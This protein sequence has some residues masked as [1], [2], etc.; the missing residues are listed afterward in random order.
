[1]FEDIWKMRVQANF[2]HSKT[3]NKFLY[4]FQNAHT[5]LLAGLFSHGW[6]VRQS[7]TQYILLIFRKRF[8]SNVIYCCTPTS[9]HQKILYCW[10]SCLNVLRNIVKAFK[11]RYNGLHSVDDICMCVYWANFNWT[12]HVSVG[13]ILLV[14]LWCISC[15]FDGRQ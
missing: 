15:I 13:Y 6:Y 5:E 10:L 1:M 11:A 3:W 2:K 8:N 4:P 12:I 9:L 14:C 7:Q